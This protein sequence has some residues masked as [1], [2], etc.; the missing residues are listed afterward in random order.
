MMNEVVAKQSVSAKSD[1]DWEN[2][3]VNSNIS[4]IDTT[5]LVD[6]QD[7]EL[8]EVDENISEGQL[9]YEAYTS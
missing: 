3:V 1:L 9:M 8:I 6:I 4:E 2:V 7:H 5:D